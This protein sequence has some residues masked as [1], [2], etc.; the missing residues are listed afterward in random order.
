MHNLIR[1][2]V[3]LAIVAVYMV[4]ATLAIYHASFAVYEVTIT[5]ILLLIS[6]ATILAFARRG[7][8]SAPLLCFVATT[9]L[10]PQSRDIHGSLSD[11]SLQVAVWIH[12]HVHVQVQVMDSIRG[13]YLKDV[14][15]LQGVIEVL[16]LVTAVGCGLITGSITAWFCRHREVH[17]GTKPSSATKWRTF[18]TVY[19]IWLAFA[20]LVAL[21]LIHISMHQLNMIVNAILALGVLA[22]VVAFG[23]TSRWSSVARCFLVVLAAYRLIVP[24]IYVWNLNETLFQF[25]TK[26]LAE[27]SVRGQ[28][29]GAMNPYTFDMVVYMTVYWLVPATLAVFSSGIVALIWREPKLSAEAG[30][31]CSVV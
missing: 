19:A 4:L 3:I 11:Q 29:P 16:S 21:S 22:V 18:L 20:A 14:P 1:L 24:E 7:R 6:A 5:T 2:V 31:G 26:P 25:L 13:P 17:D 27:A 30:Q 23:S 12:R 15:S 10:I 9:V 8:F 28:S